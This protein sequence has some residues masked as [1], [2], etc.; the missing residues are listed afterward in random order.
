M[1]LYGLCNLQRLSFGL[2]VRYAL[3]LHTLV[4]SL[5]QFQFFIIAQ[6]IVMLKHN[7]RWNLLF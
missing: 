3:L 1:Q 5:L 7:S 2:S 4:Y 6:W